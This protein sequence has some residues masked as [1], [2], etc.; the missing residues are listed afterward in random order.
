[1]LVLFI[2]R[3]GRPK[4]ALAKLTKLEIRPMPLISY[5]YEDI[6]IPARNLEN[7]Q[8]IEEY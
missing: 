3:A 8:E 6:W 5:T 2:S 1:M 4:I 7:H